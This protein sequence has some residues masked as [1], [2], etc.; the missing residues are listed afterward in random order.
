VITSTR[1]ATGTIGVAFSYTPVAAPV[2]TSYLA[3]GLPG[4]L[5]LNSTTGV[6]GGTPNVSGTFK[7]I[8]TPANA[9][10][11]GAPVTIVITILPNVTFGGG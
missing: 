2:A 9:N 10:G 8:L 6:I 4:G 1:T 7:V 11:I 3:S 5:G